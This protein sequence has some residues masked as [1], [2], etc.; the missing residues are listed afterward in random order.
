[1]VVVGGVSRV[2]VGGGGGDCADGGVGGSDGGGVGGD[3]DNGGDDGNGGGGKNQMALFERDAR[4][5]L[6]LTPPN[7][8]FE[9]GRIRRPRHR[10]GQG[11][12]IVP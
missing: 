1:M 3:G 10:Y 4:S 2:C 7:F 6:A 11:S 12:Q 9:G 5:S 8:F